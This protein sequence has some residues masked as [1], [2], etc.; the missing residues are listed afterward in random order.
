[1]GGGGGEATGK[2]LQHAEKLS[3]LI[4]MYLTSENNSFLMRDLLQSFSGIKR[5]IWPPTGAT[6]SVYQLFVGSSVSPIENEPF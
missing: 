5:F 3:R 1:M 4:K 2:C 6:G